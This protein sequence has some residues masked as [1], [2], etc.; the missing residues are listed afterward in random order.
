MPILSYDGQ[1][2][3][4][5][6]DTT[7]GS[8]SQANQRIQGR[9]LAA[10]H[11]VLRIDP[12]GAATVAPVA[13][14]CVVA[15]DGQQAG[16]S[17]VA[18]SD[19]SVIEAGQARFVYS[20][21]DAPHPSPEPEPSEAY[22]VD[23][24]ARRAYQLARRSVQ[25][26]RDAGAGITLKDPTVSRFHADVRGEAGGHVLYSSGAT[27]TMLNEQPVSAPRLLYEGDEIR[28]GRLTLVFTHASPPGIKVVP[29]AGAEESSATRRSTI[30]DMNAFREPA[31]KGIGG[32]SSSGGGVTIL[33]AVV[34]IV[35]IAIIAWLVLR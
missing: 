3:T 17:G 9:D 18:L 12:S 35:L 20:A 14:A 2:V 32:R 34:V 31:T 21:G 4:L 26:G 24:T 27:G 15:V 6:P 16:R 29:P 22:L 13:E 28:I 11:F 23:T 19:G 30:V 10:R 33:L 1:D 7:I 25:I 5:G 8:G